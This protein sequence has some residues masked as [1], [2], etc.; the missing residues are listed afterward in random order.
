MHS[1]LST[2]EGDVGFA[3]E[4]TAK[5]T[6]LEVLELTRYSMIGRLV[7]S[8]QSFLSVLNKSTSLQTLSLRGVQ[9]SHMVSPTRDVYIQ[10]GIS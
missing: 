8:F 7:F 2:A 3:E 1:Q 10:C 5:C 4:M 6:K 9:L